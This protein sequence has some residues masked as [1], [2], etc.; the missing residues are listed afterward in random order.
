MGE[1]MTRV[2]LDEKGLVPAI[3]QNASSGEVIMLG[4][5]S[6]G[7]IKRTLEGGDVWFYSRSRSDLWH[8]GELSGKLHEGAVRRHG[9]RR[10]HAPH[11]G[12]AG[13]ARSAIP[14]IQPASSPASILFPI[15]RRRKPAQ[16]S[17]KS[18]SPRYRTASVNVRRAATRPGCWKRAST[19]SA[20][21]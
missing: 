6:P 10:R 14:G 16:A 2:Q 4:Y 17:W 9:L 8:K 15:S 20:R 5:M 7:S 21:R 19:V 3:A 13:G 11:Q 1:T 12:R 18:Y